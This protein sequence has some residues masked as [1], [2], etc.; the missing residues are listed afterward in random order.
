MASST[1]RQIVVDDSDPSIIYSSAF[2]VDNTGDLNNQGNFGATLKSTLHGTNG[3]G[4]LQ[5]QFSGTQVAVFGTT[6]QTNATGHIDP[7]WECFVDS[8]SIGSMN[9]FQFVENNWNLCS[10]DG[11]PDKS[12]VLT[13]NAN[14]HG[15]TFWFDYLRYVPSA[16]VPLEN[17]LVLVDHTDRDLQYD[18]NWGPL[19]TIANMTSVNGAQVSLSFTGVSLQWYSHIP[20]ELPHRPSLATYSIDGG[21][22]NSF[23]LQG[24]GSPTQVTLYNVMEFEITSLPYGRHDITIT[25]QGDNTSTPLTLA[26]LLIQNGSSYSAPTPSATASVASLSANKSGPNVGGIVGGVLGALFFFL[27]VVAAVLFYRHWRKQYGPDMKLKNAIIIPFSTRPNVARKEV[28]TQS[29]SSSGQDILDGDG[30]LHTPYVEPVQ[31]THRRRHSRGNSRQIGQS[32]RPHH[33]SHQESVEELDEQATYY[34]GYQTWAQTKALEAK[35]RAARPR[36]SYM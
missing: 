30:P 10:A 19:G 36:D 20:T 27:S 4:S 11:L 9:P 3:T 22:E 15:R 5:F 34:G 17:A 12:H 31:P 35:S 21:A 25:F 1:P 13:I 16:N 2:F 28:D 26:Y 8:V 18:S 24:L 6:D 23:A 7:T 29:Q 14:S 32:S 33:V